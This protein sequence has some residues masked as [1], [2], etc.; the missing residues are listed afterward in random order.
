[1]LVV[2]PSIDP[3]VR[4]YAY[5]TS[6]HGY[7]LRK[8]LTVIIHCPTHIAASLSLYAILC[9]ECT[10]THLRNRYVFPEE[11]T[12]LQPSCQRRLMSDI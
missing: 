1:M 5:P 8:L 9:V 7:L 3:Y 2:N 12:F 4:N 10:G 6:Q 11:T